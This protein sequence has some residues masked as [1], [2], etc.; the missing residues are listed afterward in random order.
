MLEILLAS[1]LCRRAKRAT[2]EVGDRLD[3]HVDAEGGEPLAD[4]GES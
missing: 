3:D 4:G 1:R 2:V